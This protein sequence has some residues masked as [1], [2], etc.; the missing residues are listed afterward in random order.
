MRYELRALGRA[1]IPAWNRLLAAV[2]AV[3]AVGEHY[4][5]ADLEEELANPD[6]EVGKDVVGAYDG[7]DL[8]GFFQVYP[9]S[10]DGTHQRVI[11]HGATR[12][13]HR[14]RGLGTLLVEKM[15]A[16]AD[17]VH[18]ERHPDLPAKLALTGRS[19]RCGRCG[20]PCGPRSGPGS[21]RRARA[22]G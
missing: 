19:V 2:E 14:G 4:C 20:R 11:V 5:E 12:P 3:D 6:L 15:L 8:V 18:A 1:D 10:T 9:R 7:D 16:R 21:A 17:E 22:R 13:D